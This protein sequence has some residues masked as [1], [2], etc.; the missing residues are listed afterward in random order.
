MSVIRCWLPLSVGVIAALAACSSEHSSSSR[1]AGGTGQ[2]GAT[3]DTVPGTGQGG[4]TADIVGGTDRVG[5]A[6]G[7]E[8]GPANVTFSVDPAANAHAISANIYCI[9]VSNM[10]S[11]AVAE[12]VRDNG[13]RLVRA[14]GNRYSAYNWENNASNAGSDYLHQNDSHLGTTDTPGNAVKGVL[15]TAQSGTHG[16]LITGQL[17]DYVAADKAPAGDVDSDPADDDYEYLTTRFKQ[18]RV[19]KGDTRSVTP[20]ASDDYVNQDEFLNWVRVSYPAATVIVSLDNEP[21]LWHATHARIWQ[22]RPDYDGVVLRNVT[23][24][25]MVRDVF[26]AAKI[27]GL[28]SYGWYGWHTLQGHSDASTKGE[29]LPY[30]LRQLAAASAAAG[31]RLIDYVDIHWYPEA[32][33]GDT[34]ELRKANRVSGESTTAEAVAA[35]LQAPRSLWDT[36]YVETSWIADSVGAIG[37]IPRV[38]QQIADNYPDTELAFAEWSYGAGNHISGGLATADVLGILGRE[39]VGLACN[40]HAEADRVY[41]YGAYQLYGNYDGKG[42]R[43]GDTSVLASTSNIETTSVYAATDSSDPSRLTVIAIN[44]SDQPQVAELTI[45]GTRTYQSAAVYVLDEASFDQLNQTAHPLAHGTVGASEPGKLKFEMPAM[46]AILLVPSSDS[47]AKAVSDWLRPLPVISVGSTFDSDVQG[48]GLTADYVLAEGQTPTLSWDATEG[49]P[50]AGAL[51][52]EVPFSERPQN[53]GIRPALADRMLDL[54]NKKLIVEVKRVGAFDGGIM[55]F[56]MSGPDYTPWVSHGWTMLPSEDWVS[57]TFDPV[58]VQAA[59][60]DF[61]PA[62]IREFGIQFATGDTGAASPGPVTFFID[63]VMQLSSG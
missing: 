16:A 55:V 23:Y 21:D 13:L 29:F 60:P 44:K 46:S 36:F 17:A 39:G 9:N 26:P 8:L 27:L 31:Q 50:T 24:A 18:N 22:Q 35:R 7:Q 19:T 4:T 2:G 63:S 3:T 15:E 37:L 41:L 11:A 14:G 42:G 56:A 47:H 38:K 34:E 43:F 45:S 58:A 48:W 20:D 6:A 57:I 1:A 5:G 12:L 10:V 28:A 33:A 54:T 52:L 53:V 59:N 61:D 32:T 49:S 25:T 51:R 40:W 30:Y 62:D